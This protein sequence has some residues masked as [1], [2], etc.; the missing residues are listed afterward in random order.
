MCTR[1]EGWCVCRTLQVRIP[2]SSARSSST[3]SRK[4]RAWKSLGGR[5]DG[6]ALLFPRIL[7]KMQEGGS[8][9][10]PAVHWL[11]QHAGLT[12]T[13]IWDP[14]HRK[15]N[16]V[17]ASCWICILEHAV[18]CNG[19]LG[20]WEPQAFVYKDVVHEIWLPTICM[21][22]NEH[23]KM[24]WQ[25]VKSCSIRSHRGDKVKL[26]R[27]QGTFNVAAWWRGQRSSYLLVLLWVG[28]KNGWWKSMAKLLF[29]QMGVDDDAF[30]AM[31][32]P[33]E[34]GRIA[35]PAASTS[36]SSSSCF[37]AFIVGPAV[38]S[39]RSRSFHGCFEAI[40][41]RR[42]TLPYCEAVQR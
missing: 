17:H 5:D 4:H 33:G 10:L 26:G 23:L 16:V 13:T 30:S 25:K 18:M 15:F 35:S 24:T 28:F 9:G 31:P 2:A 37:A 7:H 39:S 40:R 36:S 27:W 3:W 8:I 12:A 11:D 1:N 38:R 19:P 34:L 41:E 42:E 32:S 21:G 29:L 20:L 6:G 22:S 14:L